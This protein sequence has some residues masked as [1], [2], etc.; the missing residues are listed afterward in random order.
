MHEGN[1][2]MHFITSAILGLFVLTGC[3]SMFSTSSNALSTDYYTDDIEAL[4]SNRIGAGSYE[5]ITE[6]SDEDWL[7]A[8]SAFNYLTSDSSRRVDLWGYRFSVGILSFPMKVIDPQE[9]TENIF[10]LMNAADTSDNA[11]IDF[12]TYEDSNYKPV[13]PSSTGGY[14]L[15]SVVDFGLGPFVLVLDQ[16]GNSISGSFVQSKPEIPRLN[17]DYR[18]PQEINTIRKKNE[19]IWALNVYDAALEYVEKE[20]GFTRSRILYVEEYPLDNYY[21]ILENGKYYLVPGKDIISGEVYPKP[22]PG[23]GFTAD[24]YSGHGEYNLEALIDREGTCSYA[25]ETGNAT[26]SEVQENNLHLKELEFQD[27]GRV[28]SILKEKGFY[29]APSGIAVKYSDDLNAT[30]I[31]D[32]STV[33]WGPEIDDI[34]MVLFVPDTGQPKLFAGFSFTDG[35]SIIDLNTSVWIEKEKIDQLEKI[36]VTDI[37][38]ETVEFSA[39]NLVTITSEETDDTPFKDYT[40]WFEVN[41]RIISELD[42]VIRHSAEYIDV[43]E[44][45]IE[46]EFT[47]PNLNCDKQGVSGMYIAKRILDTYY[48]YDAIYHEK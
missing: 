13:I 9:Q 34:P 29:V 4:S 38:G 39:S 12:Y 22:V 8:S 5:L 17:D 2:M 48:E 26:Y 32:Q 35:E 11:S 18:Y 40:C 1:G 25:Y 37:Y 42:T 6:G 43:P 30:I 33:I 20:F 41:P 24:A 46:F 19:E 14:V 3:S 44:V 36:R 27:Y 10:L 15:Y 31:T 23:A 47:N 16:D 45:K 7:Y 28:D 21:A